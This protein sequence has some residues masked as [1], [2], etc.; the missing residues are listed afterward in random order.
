MWLYFPKVTILQIKQTALVSPRPKT[1]IFGLLV[2][3]QHYYTLDGHAGLSTILLIMIH[4]KHP[5]DV[6]MCGCNLKVIL[7]KID[8]RPLR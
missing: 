4:A 1:T 7:F 3:N 6:L 5:I 2:L 8:P